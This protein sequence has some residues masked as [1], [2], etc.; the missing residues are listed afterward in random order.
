[1][2]FFLHVTR[3]LQYFPVIKNWT[4]LML[5]DSNFIILTVK[6]L[7]GKISFLFL[8][9]CMI[10]M[11][12]SYNLWFDAC[13]WMFKNLNY[14]LFCCV[15]KWIKQILCCRTMCGGL[16]LRYLASCWLKTKKTRLTVDERNSSC[17]VTLPSSET[18]GSFFI[19]KKTNCISQ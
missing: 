5:F 15:F 6:L 16:C 10:K 12:T 19:I 7:K 9:T 3:V 18:E 2:F 11:F 8:K 13:F 17:H 1:M 4:T 14:I